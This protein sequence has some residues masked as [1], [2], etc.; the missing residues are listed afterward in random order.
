M[1]SVEDFENTKMVYVNSYYRAGYTVKSS[2][3]GTVNKMEICLL[4]NQQ[5]TY[6]QNWK[7]MITKNHHKPEIIN[8]E[9]YYGIWYME[10]MSDN[11]FSLNLSFEEGF[12]RFFELI[13]TRQGEVILNGKRFQISKIKNFT[14]HKKP[15]K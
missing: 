10:Q 6:F 1:H 9:I 4:E 7:E 11:E 15:N 14:N 3:Q 2:P 13:L 12:N 8:P 5:C